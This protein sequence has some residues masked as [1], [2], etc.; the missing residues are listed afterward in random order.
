MTPEE[1]AEAAYRLWISKASEEVRRLIDGSAH[2]QLFIEVVA[3]AIAGAQ[4]TVALGSGTA[5]MPHGDRLRA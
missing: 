1:R 3:G 4:E 5:E 2:Q